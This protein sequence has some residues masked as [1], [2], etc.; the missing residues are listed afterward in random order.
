MRIYI[1]PTA[2]PQEQRDLLKQR[3]FNHEW[4]E[5]DASS[6]LADVWIAFPQ[7]VTKAH[8]DKMVH[9]KWIHLLM[10]GFNTV[11]LADLERRGIVL[12]NSKDVF[13]I[14]IA[15]DVFSKILAINR[16]VRTF[17]DQQK[18]HVWK[19][20]PNE[21][22]IYGSVVGIVGAGSIGGEVAKRM[23]AFGA[24]VHG[25]K[26]SLSEDPVYD[27]ILF[28]RDGLKELLGLSDTVILALP[29]NPQ[30]RHLINRETLSWMKPSAVLVNVARG[31]IVDQDALVDALKTNTIRAAALDV[32][33][34]EPL[35]SDHPFWDLPNLFLTPHNA[36]SSVKM[37]S[38]MVDL[39]IE[40][41]ARYE[42]GKPLLHVVK[43][44]SD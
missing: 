33:T 18:L 41:L 43:T 19:T 31:E 37:L 11:D 9:L 27:R 39:T 12:T 32:T 29:L 34:P 17:H 8:L 30:T 36:S 1:R 23:K 16:D 25:W 26:R 44:S 35:P 14:Q 38:R 5:D 21:R 10:A 28:G 4:I 2:F 22:E 42:A 6:H 7:S 20:V 24:V 3:F 13:S 40:N 15:E